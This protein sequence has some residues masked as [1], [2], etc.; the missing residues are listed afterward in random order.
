MSPLITI[1]IPIFNRE[2]LI[3]ETL[4]AVL[5]QTYKNW[6]CILI[7][8]GS[9][10]ASV[11]IAKEYANSDNRFKVLQRSERRRKGAATCRNIGIENSNG[12]YIQFL[13]SDDLLESNK[14][15]SQISKLNKS[16]N[17]TLSTC[18]WG[19]L[20]KGMEHPKKYEKLP[21]YKDF[22]NPSHL[23][24]IFGTKETFFPVHC[25][26]TPI[27]LINKA[28]KWNEEL[29]INDDGEYF[30]RVLLKAEQIIFDDHTYAIYRSGSGNRLSQTETNEQI[31]QYIK[32]WNSID[33]SIQMALETKNHTYIIHA[34]TLLYY[35]IKNTHPELIS[36][37]S[38][39]FKNRRSFI[40]N[41]FFKIIN[42]IQRS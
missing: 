10:D 7:D 37:Y 11:K 39:F 27:Q 35:K 40:E 3:K 9:V 30:S 22:K 6:E 34:K 15:E 29:T 5:K 19:R 21:I 4:D 8:D 17:Y 42:R 13:D 2:H 24:K 1:I 33:E 41:M 31:R 18:K 26:L 36:E 25:Y 20:D 38:Q 28:G 23:L 12:S 16:D 32:S 14:L